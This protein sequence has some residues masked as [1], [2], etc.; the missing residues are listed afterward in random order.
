M[1]DIAILQQLLNRI[2][3]QWFISDD[4]NLWRL[5]RCHV[6]EMVKANQLVMLKGTHVTACVAGKVLKEV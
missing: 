4:L 6:D 3:N 1:S 5:L 2:V